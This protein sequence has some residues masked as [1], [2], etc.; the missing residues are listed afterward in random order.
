MFSTIKGRFLIGLYIFLLVSVPTGFYLASQRQN[1]KASAQSKPDKTITQVQPSPSLI[2]RTLVSS[3]SPVSETTTATLGPVMDFILNLEGRL[4]N[5]QSAKIF[6]GIAEGGIVTNPKYLLTFSVDLPNDGRFTNLSLAGLTSGSRYTAYLKGPAQIATA[7][8]FTMSSF[9]THLNDSQTLLGLS[10]DLNDDNTIDSTDL[11]IM[12]GLLGVFQT[13][14]NY[15]ENADINLD[16]II[17]ST[18]L[19]FINKNI[20]TIGTSGVWTSQPPKP[21]G[22][23]TNQPKVL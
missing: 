1:Q 21:A 23:L 15:N 5:K 18:D 14:A 9:T 13:A 22:G 20:N 19:G 11:T 6:V 3:P 7:S 4:L 10:G 8:A 16:G 2:P 12:K 17:N